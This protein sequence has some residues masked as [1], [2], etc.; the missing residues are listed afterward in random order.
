MFSSCPGDSV[1][2]GRYRG[3]GPHY[4]CCRRQGGDYRAG[5]LCS[6]ASYFQVPEPLSLPSHLELVSMCWGKFI[7]CVAVIIALPFCYC[8]SAVKVLFLH[9]GLGRHL[10]S[11]KVFVTLYRFVDFCCFFLGSF[12]RNKFLGLPNISTNSSAM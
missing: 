4:H 8:H 3:S 6:Q 7:S 5:R 12:N 11:H 10:V 2:G 1:P 9:T